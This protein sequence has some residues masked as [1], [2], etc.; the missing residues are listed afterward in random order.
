MAWIDGQIVVA[1]PSDSPTARNAKS[2]GRARAALDGA[3][4][5]VIFDADVAVI[6]FDDAETSLAARYVDR[7][8]WNPRNSPGVWSP[9]VLTP[10]R[11]Q[12]W[13]SPS[14]IAGRTIIRDGRWLDHPSICP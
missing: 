5:V 11:A 9:L 10:R 6:D 7:V 2:S 13:N 1:T 14:E 4:D 8:G 3:V 12:A